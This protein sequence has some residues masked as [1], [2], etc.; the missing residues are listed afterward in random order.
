MLRI[1]YVS[2]WV[3]AA[4]ERA[5]GYFFIF[6][7]I[8]CPQ[9]AHASLEQYLALFSLS[10]SKK[11]I[12]KLRHWTFTVV[13][14]IADP[15]FTLLHVGS[16]PYDFLSFAEHKRRHFEGFLFSSPFHSMGTEGFMFQNGVKWDK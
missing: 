6:A 4:H 3:C 16:N 1:A 10:S 7:R 11:T 8:P 2:V 9:S 12:S 13:K 14:G 15:M 5:S